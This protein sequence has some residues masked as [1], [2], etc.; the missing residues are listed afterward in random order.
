M[1]RKHLIPRKTVYIILLA[2]AAVLCA[3][4]RILWRTTA[5]TTVAIALFMLALLF[6]IPLI[7]REDKHAVAKKKNAQHARG[8]YRFPPADKGKILPFPGARK[9]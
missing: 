2:A 6:L 7:R 1:N 9:R 4:L 8:P 3:T 5:S